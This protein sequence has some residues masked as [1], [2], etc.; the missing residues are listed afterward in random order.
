MTA[1]RPPLW[2]R[3]GQAV[4]LAAPAGAVD[5][6]ALEAG[7]ALL[8]GLL[9][10]VELL[11]GPE[12]LD[13]Q[14][15]LAGTDASRAEHLTRLML[16]PAAG[17]VLSAR[18]GYGCSRLLPLLDLE[19]LAASRKLLVG[20][21]DLTCLLNALASRGLV[22]AHGPMAVRLAATDQA[23]LDDLAGLLAGRL[24]WP[25][26]FAGRPLA[27]GRARGPLMGGNLTLFCHLLGTPWFPELTGAV[28]FLEELGE[29]AYRLDRCFTQ[30][31]LAGV[32]ER[33]VGVALGSLS[34]QAEDPPEL[35]ETA[36]ERLSGLGLPV[37]TGLPFGHG[38]LN[39]PLP[40]G[41]LAELDGQA[42]TFA[43]GLDLA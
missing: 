4:A 42:G 19:A 32:F 9:P 13:R 36:V 34:E 7:L 25:A 2:P 21:S 23:S 3:P 30:L 14:G 43:V 5:P 24:P 22:T 29:P 20:F 26:L 33:V 41:A 17:A 1:A 38:P 12:L 31:I 40:L 39:R 15:Y 6:Q 16:S 35:L 37:V 10:G 18:G 11:A 27:P 8:K 28:L